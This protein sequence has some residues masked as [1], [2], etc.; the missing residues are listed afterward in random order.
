[1]LPQE[2]IGRSSGLTGAGCA[3]VERE[4]AVTCSGKMRRLRNRG[5][6]ISV[7]RL[8][9]LLF[10]SYLICVTIHHVNYEL[11]IFCQSPY[12]KLLG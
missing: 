9:F 6:R 12:L 11:A 5:K 1:M 10:I 8:L 7:F 3:E 4:T 2:A